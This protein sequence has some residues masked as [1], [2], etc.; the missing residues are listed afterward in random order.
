L[1]LLLFVPCIDQGW[2][3]SIQHREIQREEFSVAVPFFF[4]LS[5]GFYFILYFLGLWFQRLAVNLLPRTE[6]FHVKAP[7]G[8]RDTLLAACVDAL[9]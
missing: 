4:S 5:L 3:Y 7:Q 6:D 9:V 1:L 2:I 8:M